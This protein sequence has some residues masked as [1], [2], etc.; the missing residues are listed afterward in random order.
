MY[1]IYL[2]RLEGDPPPLFDRSAFR[3]RPASV[4]PAYPHSRTRLPTQPTQATS[5]SRPSPSPSPPA[6]CR[7]SRCVGFDP[8]DASTAIRTA[9][10]LTVPGR[11][12][13]GSLSKALGTVPLHSGRVEWQMHALTLTAPSLHWQASC[14]ATRKCA[15]SCSASTPQARPVR[16]PMPCSDEP[17]RRAGKARDGRGL[18]PR[19]PGWRGGALAN[20]PFRARPNNMPADRWLLVNSD[21]VQAQ[22]QPERDDDPD[23]ESASSWTRCK[24]VRC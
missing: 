15:S 24:R 20:L 22:A 8:S 13:G 18:C 14:L 11:T 21:P 9:R 10:P 2:V 17:L 6:R 23:G 4:V 7:C 12:V 16:P 19:V 1:C 3:R 5:K